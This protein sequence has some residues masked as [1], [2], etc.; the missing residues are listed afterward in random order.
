MTPAE[1]ATELCHTATRLRSISYAADFTN[2]RHAAMSIALDL[3]AS[4]VNAA[5]FRIDSATAER[6]SDELAANRPPRP[7]IES[8]VTS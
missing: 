6:V 1:L 8:E 7:V 5:A 4:A 3:A 2:P